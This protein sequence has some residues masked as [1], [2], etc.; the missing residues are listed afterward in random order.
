[1]E[2]V[3]IFSTTDQKGGASIASQRLHSKFL[4]KKINSQMFVLQKYSN[5]STVNRISLNI[6]IVRF[7][8]KLDSF[9]LKFYRKRIRYP[10]NVGFLGVPT[11]FIRPLSMYPSRIIINFVPGLFSIFSLNKFKQP[12]FILHDTWLLTGGCHT[13]VSCEGYKK[14]CITC[15]HL[16]TEGKLSLPFIMKKIKKQVLSNLDATL[17]CPSKWMYKFAVESKVVPSSNIHYIPNIPD[18]KN[19]NYKT[20]R[21]LIHHSICLIGGHNFKDKAK[22]TIYL[23]DFLIK[24]KKLSSQEILVNVISGGCDLKIDGC[25]INNIP[26]VNNPAY[27][28]KHYLNSKVL[29][30]FSLFENLSNT[31][32]EAGLCGIPA[33]C[34]DVGG[35]SEI[36]NFENEVNAIPFADT[37]QMAYRTNKILMMDTSDYRKYSLKISATLKKMF[38]E[39]RIFNHYKKIIGL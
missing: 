19:F 9:I 20:D 2:K 11:F 29:V 39:E 26:E 4:S 25:I 1:M 32:I 37:T 33:I 7:I 17:I 10:W 34:W 27:M 24:L 12:I 31:I 16:Q 30:H 13:P 6:L 3:I 38:N 15:P 35:N 23:E 18:F 21:K 22:G 5:E 8:S 14:D 28:A 36:S